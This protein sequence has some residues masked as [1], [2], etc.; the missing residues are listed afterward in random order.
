MALPGSG[1][2]ASPPHS[3]FLIGQFP[4]PSLPPNLSIPPISSIA[5]LALKM[6]TECFSETLATTDKYARRQNP[7][8]H[9]HPHRRENLKS[10]NY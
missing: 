6:E 3:S 9:H 4:Q 10:H 2:E 8:D 7:D 5:T 1:S